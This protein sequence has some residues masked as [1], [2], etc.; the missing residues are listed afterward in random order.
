MLQDSLRSN[1]GPHPSGAIFLSGGARRRPQSLTLFRNIEGPK[2][3]AAE[4]LPS[5]EVILL[6]L[7]GW[8]GGRGV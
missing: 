4:F 8:S 1:R 6:G 2:Y 5:D 7:W 3:T